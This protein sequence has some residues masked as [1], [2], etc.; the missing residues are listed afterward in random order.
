MF[1]QS[2]PCPSHFSSNTRFVCLKFVAKTFTVFGSLSFLSLRYSSSLII[3]C[4]RFFTSTFDNNPSSDKI[5][6]WIFQNTNTQI[7]NNPNSVMIVP[8]LWSFS[9]KM[10]GLIWAVI[11]PK[12]TC[13]CTKLVTSLT[14]CNVMQRTIWKMTCNYSVVDYNK[15]NKSTSGGIQKFNC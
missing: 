7:P 3:L 10:I 14:I 12:W 15:N 2:F 1:L 8:T 11:A 9:V 13:Q 4:N 5:L 6:D